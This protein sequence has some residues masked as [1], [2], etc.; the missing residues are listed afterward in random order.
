MSELTMI[1][2]RRSGLLLA[3]LVPS[4]YL[5]EWLLVAATASI[6]SWLRHQHYSSEQIWLTFWVG[7]L[8][9]S[10]T[11]I[12]CN[13]LLRVDFTLMQGLRKLTEATQRRSIWLGFLLELG[14]FIRLLLWDGPCQLLIYCR[15]RL[16][17]TLWQVAFL[18]AASGIQM[19][20]WSKIYNLGY[21]GI[22]ELLTSLKGRLL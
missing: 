9:V 5:A 7:N 20:I 21:E 15:S 8:L 22:G 19:F 4:F 11:F 17:S 2:D 1:K 16:P 6:F 14:I 10:A 18:I 13:D 3:T 12:I